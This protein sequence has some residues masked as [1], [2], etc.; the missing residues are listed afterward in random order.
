ME[1]EQ[2]KQPTYEELVQA[3]NNMV[4]MVEEARAEL[5]AVKSDKI[6]ERLTTMMRILENKDVYPDKIYK[7]AVWHAEQI[8]AKPKA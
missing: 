7:L 8:M 4:R 3:Y 2:V 6:L 1:N 5:Q